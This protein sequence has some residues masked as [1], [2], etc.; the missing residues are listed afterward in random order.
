MVHVI[1]NL[2]N[3]KGQ[4]TKDNWIKRKK[5][6]Q[7]LT[8]KYGLKEALSK[9]LGL[10]HLERLN[11]KEGTRYALYQTIGETIPKCKNLDDLKYEL[12]RQGIE[13][14]INTKGKQTSCRVLVLRLN[15][16]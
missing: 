4:T 9:N 3:N 1:A 5:V 11:E 8:M 6:A 15:Y 2:I 16:I 10:T 7:Q 13:L 14:Y 12:A